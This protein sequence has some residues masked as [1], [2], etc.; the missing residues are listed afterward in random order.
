M[1]VFNGLR[2]SFLLNACILTV[3]PI[4]FSSPLLSSF[5]VSI[6][7][8]YYFRYC[9]CFW[10][11][12]LD[13]CSFHWFCLSFL[14][15][16]IAHFMFLFSFAE[17]Y[18][19]IA[20]FFFLLVVCSSLLILFFFIVL[21]CFVAFCSLYFSFLTK[22]IMNSALEVLKEVW[23]FMQSHSMQILQTRCMADFRIVM[24][25]ESKRKKDEGD[26]QGNMR[27]RLFQ[28]TARQI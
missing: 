7:V 22:S 14:C 24:R 26:N 18:W 21:V 8:Y 17:C 1:C 15:D 12:Q 16:F 2:C 5:T 13:C 11:C 23:N 19:W 4:L 6:T 28:Y 27:E 3:F 25:S 10:Y 20:L 9:F